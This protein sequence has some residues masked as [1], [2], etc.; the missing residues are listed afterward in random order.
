[1]GIIIDSNLD[2]MQAL[3]DHPERPAP[4]EIR[5]QLRLLTLK[6]WSYDGAVHQGQLVVNELI[7]NR[8]E[9]AF[10]RMFNEHVPIM[11]MIPAAAYDWDD[12]R[13]MEDNATSG[14]NFRTI[15]STETLS[16]HAQGL[17]IDID[18]FFNPL[19]K[20]DVVLPHEAVYDLSRPGTLTSDSA[21][22]HIFKSLGFSWGGD[23]FPE[24]GYV[25]YQHFDLPR[26]ATASLTLHT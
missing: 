4:L 16:L 1:M 6:Y 18:P 20:G 17:A 11:K 9:A 10:T 19:I 25:D 8:T 13:S 26:L 14:Y 2:I 15:A 23:W 3:A 5:S 7:V 22:V 24:R 21:T 12:E